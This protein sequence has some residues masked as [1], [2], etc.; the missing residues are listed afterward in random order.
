VARLT[1]QPDRAAV[2]LDNGLRD[3]QPQARARR[4]ARRTRGAKIALEQFALLGQRDSGPVIGHVDQRVIA[5][6]GGADG[7]VVPLGSELRGVRDQVGEHLC[8]APLVGQHRGEAIWKDDVD[9]LPLLIEQRLE[10]GRGAFGH[11]QQIDGTGEDRELAGAD[12]AGVEHVLDQRL[13]PQ[14][15]ALDT[16]YGGRKLGPR[17]VRMVTGQHL[18]RG[19]KRRERRPHLVRHREEVFVLELIEL[20][21]LGIRVMQAAPHLLHPLGELGHLVATLDGHR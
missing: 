19:H 14:C 17:H 13:H 7:N 3:C 12:A 1:L 5:L 6:G 9:R 10:R 2:R 20:T 18:D 4:R 16:P 8:Q 15:S 11:G 21:K